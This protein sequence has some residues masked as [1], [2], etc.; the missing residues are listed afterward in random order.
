MK[1]VKGYFFEMTED[2]KKV[3][4]TKNYPKRWEQDGKG[5]FLIKVNHSKKR[6]EVGYVTNTHRI[7]K[8]FLGTTA[9]ELY[10]AIIHEKLISKV[11]HAAY[12]GKELYKAELALKKKIEYI[13]DKE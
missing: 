11:T 12:L 10:H 3:I 2:I 7:T 9:E 8:K 4:D 5:Y 13:Q 6:I 1:K